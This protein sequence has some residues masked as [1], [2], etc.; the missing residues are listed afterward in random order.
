MLTL[1]GDEETGGTWGTSYLLENLPVANGDAMLSGDAGSPYV[2]RFGEKGQIWIEVTATG[3][4]NHGAHVHLGR[5]AIDA[6]ME[7][8]A[9]MSRLR[10]TPSPVSHAIQSAME[11]ARAISEEVSGA[12]EFT[13]LGSITV[14]IGTIRGGQAVNIIPNHAHALVDIRV[15]PGMSYRRKSRRRS[16]PCWRTCPMFRRGFWPAASRP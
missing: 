12:G 16:M 13:T 7:A 1:V 2:L 11:E 6:L 8:L 9:R 4:S 5:N 10:E 14:N 15:S 3:V